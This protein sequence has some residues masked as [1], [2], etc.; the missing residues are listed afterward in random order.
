MHEVSVMPHRPVIISLEHVDKSYAA[1]GRTVSIL[2][3]ASLKLEEGS[4]TVVFGVSGTGKTTLLNLIGALDYPD[5]GRIIVDG[6][7]LTSMSEKQRTEFRRAKLGFVFQF[8]N[9]L[10][11]LTAQENVASAIELVSTDRSE[12]KQRA[13]EYL[14]RVGLAHKAHEFP[15]Q[16]S[17]GEQQRVAIARALAKRP[18]VLLADEPTGNLDEET[19]LQIAGL[20]QLINR[21]TATTMVI[22][23]HNPKIREI[24]DRVVSIEKLQIVNKGP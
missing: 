23:T 11:T 10:P 13:R 12:I 17:G 9:L 16:L 2:K 22:V 1:A 24:A 7:D 19:S 8:F 15:D 20:F 5:A 6:Y 14:E 21:E 18:R 4:L 3:G